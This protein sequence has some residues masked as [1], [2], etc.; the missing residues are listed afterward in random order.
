MQSGWK[1]KLAHL[2]WPDV[3]DADG[4]K[5]AADHAFGA[6]VCVSAVTALMAILS[7]VGVKIPLIDAWSLVDAGLFAL[8]AL[9]I[10]KMW[11]SAA[12]IALVLF[13]LERVAAGKA[14]GLIVA[15]ILTAFFISG[16]RGTF[17]YRRM[18]K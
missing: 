1:K 12:T 2:Y 16:V 5:A 3:D 18:P 7:C 17:A 8:L 10:R 6:A 9:G 14:N 4:A 15:A 13:V 11:R